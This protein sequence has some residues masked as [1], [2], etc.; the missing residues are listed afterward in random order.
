[1]MLLLSNRS[2]GRTTQSV[3]VRGVAKNTRRAV[4]CAVSKVHSRKL[5]K[6]RKRYSQRKVNMCSNNCFELFRKIKHRTKHEIPRI[7]L[8]ILHLLRGNWLSV[9]ARINGRPR[10]TLSGVVKCKF[11]KY[12]NEL[13]ADS[14]K[15][16]EKCLP[17]AN[18]FY[19]LLRQPFS[20]YNLLPNGTSLD[21]R[22]LVRLLLPFVNQELH[23][24]S[25]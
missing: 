22:R 10:K 4:L 13:S 19:Y 2:F 7:F 24:Q 6:L 21:V 15:L 14:Y 8:L 12:N 17:I 25:D 5:E 20:N 1:M 16:K 11:W 23:I 9:Q 3:F 18:K